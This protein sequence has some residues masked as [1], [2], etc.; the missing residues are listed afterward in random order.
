MRHKTRDKSTTNQIKFGRH[1]RGC[2]MAAQ[3]ILLIHWNLDITN[4][5]FCPSS[6]KIHKKETRFNESSLQRTEFSSPLAFRY[7]VVPLPPFHI[8]SGCFYVSLNLVMSP[9]VRICFTSVT[10]GS[11]NSQLLKMSMI[12]K[13]K[14]AL[15]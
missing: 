6:S 11:F 13:T 8:I 14:N 5:I 3:F 1:Q 4:D 2:F 7:V 10:Y 12:L 9:I 15:H